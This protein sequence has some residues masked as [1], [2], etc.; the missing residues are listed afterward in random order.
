MAAAPIPGRH[1]SV[2]GVVFVHSCARAVAPHVSWAMSEVLRV[3]VSLDWTDQPVAAGTLRTESSWSGE[4]GTGSRLTS[5]LHA[6]RQL[7]FEVTEEPSPG[8]EGERYAVTPSLGLFRAT[9]G[10]HG[11][12]LVP[13]DRLRSVLGDLGDRWGV[14]RGGARPPSRG[15][16]GRGAGAVPLRR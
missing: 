14:P 9:I 7:R 6:F 2:R 3:P 13:E 11:D 5:A 16:L 12:V 1:V 8:R 4:P 10:V 15:A